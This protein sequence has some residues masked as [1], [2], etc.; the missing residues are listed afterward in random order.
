MI[1]FDSGSATLVKNCFKSGL[2]NLTR[3]MGQLM[4]EENRLLLALHTLAA[5]GFIFLEKHSYN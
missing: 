2:V 3:N 4:S 5:L 1:L